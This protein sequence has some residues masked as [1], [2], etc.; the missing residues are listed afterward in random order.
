[1]DKIQLYHTAMDACVFLL[2]NKENLGLNDYSIA[3]TLGQVFERISEKLSNQVYT[4]TEVKK[5]DGI[6]KEV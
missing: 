5:Q 1:M 2:S 3:M 4:L 6:S